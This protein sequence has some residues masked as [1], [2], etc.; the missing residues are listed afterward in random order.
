MKYFLEQQTEKENNENLNASLHGNIDG[1]QITAGNISHGI[2]N[3][4][5]MMRDTSNIY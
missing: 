3:L 2:F 1:R 4:E 5:E